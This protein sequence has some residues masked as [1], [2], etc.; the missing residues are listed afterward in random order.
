MFILFSWKREGI[1]PCSLPNCLR[2]TLS[3]L[4]C[5]LF[6]TKC[7]TG[8]H[9]HVK[10]GLCLHPSS[11][12]P[13][14]F[15]SD[16]H[17]YMME[18]FLSLSGEISCP[19][20]SFCRQDIKDETQFLLH[21]YSLSTSSELLVGRCFLLVVIIILKLCVVSSHLVLMLASVFFEVSL[22]LSIDFSLYLLLS[23]SLSLEGSA[24]SNDSLSDSSP[25]VP[26][27]P[28][29]VVQPVQTAQQVRCNSIHK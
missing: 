27:V 28:T 15:S 20:L 9:S 11:I 6:R 14:P 2:P 25:P 13:F 16:L 23:L 29:Q 12:F 18:G 22:I 8:H 1:F 7:C 24:H 17:V 21:A 26:G 10:P 3:R 5:A 4:W 19:R